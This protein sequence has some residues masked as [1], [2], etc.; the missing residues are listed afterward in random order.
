MR[1]VLQAG[2]VELLFMFT[3]QCQYVNKSLNSI[4]SLYKPIE[5]LQK[6]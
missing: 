4:C 1:F 5:S 6:I 3:D 2:S